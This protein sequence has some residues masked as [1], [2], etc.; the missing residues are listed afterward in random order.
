M[1]F[2]TLGGRK[3]LKVNDA[4][5]DSGAQ[6]TIF[7]SS[8]ME[9]SGIQLTGMQKSKVDLRVANNAMID[10]QGVVDA[11]I[12][13]LSPSGKPFKTT[14]RVYNVRNVDEVY[15]S[16]VVLVGLRIVNEFFPVAGAGNQHGCAHC[17]AASSP[18]CKSLPRKPPPGMPEH[19]PMAPSQSNIA[20]MKA[21]LLERYGAS[22]INKYT[23]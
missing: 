5:A 15:L 12:S 16:L 23:H 11:T 17:A 10:V 9:S 7:P 3:E 20:E 21:W 4:V 22:S 14:S 19:L 2:V 18:W 13:A 1:T 8:L 6:I